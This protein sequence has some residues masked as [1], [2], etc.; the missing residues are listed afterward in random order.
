MRDAW[1]RGES[2]VVGKRDADPYLV[3]VCDDPLLSGC[4]THALKK[5]E[6]VVYN[7]NYDLVDAFDNPCNCGGEN[8][9]G[10][11]VGDDHFKKLK[12]LI[13]KRDKKEEEKKAA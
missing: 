1:A 3:N 6:E 2:V 5:G 4:L 7:Y 11:M 9:Q 10:Y 8:C 12:K 13:R